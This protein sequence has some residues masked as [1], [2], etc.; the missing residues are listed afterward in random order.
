MLIRRCNE[1]DS[2]RGPSPHGLIHISHSLITVF[3]C[4]KG[5]GSMDSDLGCHFR[6]VPC[7]HEVLNQCC[8]NVG[9]SSKTAGKH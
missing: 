2:T 7:K 1:R 6:P 8:F 3:T 9:P 5:L 4:E